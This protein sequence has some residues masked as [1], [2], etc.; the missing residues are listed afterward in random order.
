MIANGPPN[1]DTFSVG[2][3]WY[4]T[5]GATVHTRALFGRNEQ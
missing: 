3:T 4:V 5:I 2:E 1:V